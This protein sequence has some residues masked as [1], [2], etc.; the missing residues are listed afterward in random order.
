MPGEQTLNPPISRQNGNTLCQ[1]KSKV[2]VRATAMFLDDDVPKRMK[3]YEMAVGS[4]SMLGG[5]LSDGFRSKKSGV[6]KNTN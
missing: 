2:D 1:I 5:L 3:V 4:S 6:L